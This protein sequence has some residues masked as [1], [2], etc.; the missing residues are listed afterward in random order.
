MKRGFTLIE[1][2]V[3]IAIIALLMAILMPALNKAK[4]QA[5]AVVCQSNLRQWGAVCLMYTGDNGGYFMRGYTGPQTTKP[6]DMW[7]DAMR[8]CYSNEPKIRCCPI[9]TKPMSEGGRNPFAAWS[10][11]YGGFDFIYHGSYGLN[12]WVCN[13]PSDS[14][15]LHDNKVEIENHWRSADV[16]DAANIPLFLDSQLLGGRPNHTNTPPKYDGQPWWQAAP[17]CMNRF[18]INRHNGAVNSVFLDFS[19]RKIGLKQLWRLKWHRRF[20]INHMHGPWPDWM[21]KFKDY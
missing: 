19:V 9:A 15:W 12:V 8:S 11:S 2:L 18:C 7:I 14:T 6:G 10:W 3:V 20:D 21:K 17:N 1:L 16:R 5:K 4:K 13:P